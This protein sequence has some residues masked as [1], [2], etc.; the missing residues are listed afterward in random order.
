[1][2]NQTT[3]HGDAALLQVNRLVKEFEI[4]DAALRSRTLRAVDGVDF[5]VRKKET[6]AIVGES[7]SG[8]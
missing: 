1:M 5:V 7:G 8:K 2:T 3:T 6:F 4:K